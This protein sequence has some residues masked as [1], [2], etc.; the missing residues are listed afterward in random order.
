MLA[1]SDDG[2]GMDQEILGQIFEPFFTTKGVG[3]GTGLGLAMVYGI[4][5]QNHGFIDV[6]S[7]PGEGTAFRIYLPRHVGEAAPTGQEGP[8]ESVSRGNE[9][10]LLVED[11]PAMLKLGM[12][13]LKRLG[14]EVLVADLPGTAIEL[15]EADN[16]AIH[17]V[18]TD[19]V[20]PGMNGRDLARRLQSVHPGITCL[21]MSGYTADVIA[22]HGVL[23]QGVHF[24]QKPFSAK[25][26][27]AKVREA[28]EG[29]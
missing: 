13:M 15:A 9:T 5:E 1:V 24:I 17:L 12:L 20:M 25:H 14:Y 28:I 4:V 11:E 27:A 21:F 26:L 2:S 3:Q 22:R 7:A 19:V 10:V 29:G 16:G 6:Y 8:E 18:I 23:D